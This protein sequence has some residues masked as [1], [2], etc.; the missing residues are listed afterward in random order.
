MYIAT[1]KINGITYCNAYKVGDNPISRW[2][3][4]VSALLK[5]SIRCRK[6]GLSRKEA[7]FRMKERKRSRVAAARLGVEQFFL[8][9]QRYEGARRS[10]TWDIKKLVRKMR[11]SGLLEHLQ[12]CKYNLTYNMNS[13]FDGKVFDCKV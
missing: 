7:N 5:Q 3:C 4:L 8:Q 2:H 9:R 10:S 6:G 13:K 1:E 11:I 12:N